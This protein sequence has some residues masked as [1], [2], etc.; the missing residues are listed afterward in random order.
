[1]RRPRWHYIIGPGALDYVDGFAPND[2]YNAF[3]DLIEALQ[4]G[5]YPD[6]DLSSGVLELR[7]PSKPNGFSAPFNRGLVAYQVMLDQPVIKLVDVFW[8]DDD[9]EGLDYG[10]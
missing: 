5:P 1:M 7:D 4:V 6:D 2:V 8:M 3:Y 10:L 9:G